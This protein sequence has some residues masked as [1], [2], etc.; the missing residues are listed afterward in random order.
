[1]TK[2]DNLKYLDRNFSG[3]REISTIDKELASIV[4]FVEIVFFKGCKANS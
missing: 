1:M 4:N 3:F 2:N